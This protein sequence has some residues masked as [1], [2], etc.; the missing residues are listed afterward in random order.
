MRRLA[1]VV[2]AAALALAGCSDASPS[3]SMSPGVGR[4]GDI[5][6]TTS[7][8]RAPALDFTEGLTFDRAESKVLWPGDGDRLVDGQPLLLDIFVQSLETG[9]VLENTYDFLPRSFLLVP[10]LLGDDLYLLLREQRVGARVLSVAPSMDEFEDETDIAIVI[11][12]LADHA[13]GETVRSTVEGITIT[14]SA[15]HEPR[16]SIPAGQPM[17]E[18]LTVATLI[19]GAG[20]QVQP[21]SFAVLQYAVIFAEEG[22]DL[23][24][25]WQPGDVFDSTWPVERAPYEVQIG[26]GK[27]IRALEEGLIDQSVGSRVAIIAP[28]EWAYPGKGTLVIVVDILDVY[29][30]VK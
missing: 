28:D 3:P 19:R 14:Q 23:D 22:T 20:E 10:E 16:V 26:V 7:D 21:G 17:P 6:V 24:G 2:I 11:D 9:E 27:A 4:I 12:V 5:T 15:T 30:E 18:T 1:A 8:T 25:S 29:N 13:V